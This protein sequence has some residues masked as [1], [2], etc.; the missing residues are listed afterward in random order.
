[1]GLKGSN[2]H[3]VSHVAGKKIS[4]GNQKVLFVK[5]SI[6]S[7]FK[8]SFIVFHT[9]FRMSGELGITSQEECPY[10]K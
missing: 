10:S 3:S 8:D 5:F 4:P 6:N 7:I 1:M 9:F 2:I